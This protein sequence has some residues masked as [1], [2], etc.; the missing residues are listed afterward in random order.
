MRLC[1]IFLHSLS[2]TDSDATP[3]GY[4][5]EPEDNSTETAETADV[6]DQAR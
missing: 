6:E 4:L 3:S 5:S 1:N 2:D